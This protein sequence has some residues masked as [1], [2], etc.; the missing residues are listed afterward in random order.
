M[1]YPDFS[2][3]KPFTGVNNRKP[4]GLAYRCL[5][6]AP[7]WQLDRYLLLHYPIIWRTKVHFF[8]WFSLILGYGLLFGLGEWLPLQTTNLP[9]LQQVDI[10]VAV[11]RLLGVMVLAWWGYTQFRSP[12]MESHARQL[13]LTG[14]IY[15]LCFFSVMINPLALVVP[16]VH[17]IAQ[18]M[19]D[20]EF[21]QEYALHEK[22]HFWC[23]DKGVTKENAEINRQAIVDTL[24]KYGFTASFEFY[25]QNAVMP[26]GPYCRLNSDDYAGR[27]RPCLGFR[28]TNGV[29]A[30][31]L[32]RDRLFSL[33]EAKLMGSS[34]G[35]YYKNYIE[36]VPT[37]VM[38]SAAWAGAL[39]LAVYPASARHRRFDR[40]SSRPWL[41][42]FRLPQP[43]ALHRL[44]KFLRIHHPM[45]WSTRL[46]SFLLN[47][48]VYGG[49]VILATVGLW[50]LLYPDILLFNAIKDSYSIKSVL[51]LF[52]LVPF[53]S[54]GWVVQQTKIPINI[55]AI[56][57]NRKALLLYS[58]APTIFPSLL[59]ACLF[60]FGQIKSEDAVALWG[61]CS[62]VC[63]FIAGVVFL[64]KHIKR[65]R[66]I[67][68]AVF[69]SQFIFVASLFLN[70]YNQISVYAWIL[71]W[72][73]IAG[74]FAWTTKKKVST[75]S[76]VSAACYL[77][78]ITFTIIIIIIFIP[79][80]YIE[81]TKILLGIDLLIFPFFLWAATPAIRIL[82]RHH[83]WPK[84]E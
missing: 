40:Q 80:K 68:L 10:G 64:Q 39:L 71:S 34:Q 32:F 35:A 13:L 36:T 23:C 18:L 20:A 8:I 25:P 49:L 29:Y 17:R 81:N 2:L 42:K 11:L 58:L 3:D 50:R 46:H 41:P 15:F 27:Y 45:V 33:H 82:I 21:Q 74:L 7:L 30:P 63:M 62:I 73:I 77:L 44:D 38:I 14:L 83:Y 59:I 1:A 76:V 78:S 12:M 31:L 75:L 55:T 69:F 6:P 28:S 61:I 47:A 66:D 5:V 37:W 16:V 56:S 26:D 4:R 70:K 48:I 65:T 24:V 60:I 54:V 43:S 9:T 84:E 72:M 19:P 57:A 22:N 53:T 52:F 51:A 67:F 79:N